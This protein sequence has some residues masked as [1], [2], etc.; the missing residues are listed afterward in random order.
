MKSTSILIIEDE[1]SIRDM[2][3]FALAPDGFTI[4]EAGDVS[5][6]KQKIAQQLP[7]LILLDWMLPGI[8]GIDFAKQL[9]R[10]P[11]TKTI[12]IIILTA[13]AEED[14]KVKGFE[15]GADDYITK[16][17]SPRELSMR[18]KAVL[19][20]GPLV[21]PEDIIQIKNLYL[22]ISTHQLK[23][24]DEFITLTPIEYKLLY[25]FVTHQERVYS[26]E[27]LLDYVW[28]KA[29]YI[30]ERTVDVQIRRLR[31]RLKPYGY[32]GYIKTMRGS[33]Y[34]FIRNTLS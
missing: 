30:D 27:Q 13:R 23:I 28:G 25:F 4:L 6:A 11:I 21:S 9:K 17:F 34:Q 5:T 32:D 15:I 20:R 14:N 8:S 12:P 31:N 18:I 7:D 2:I 10:D 19:R 16:P 3:Q 26:R 22:N 29:N 1:T 24:N 33:G